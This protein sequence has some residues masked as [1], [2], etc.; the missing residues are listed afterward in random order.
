MTSE[1]LRAVYRPGLKEYRVGIVGAGVTGL[2][3]ARSLLQFGIDNVKIFERMPNLSDTGLR[4]HGMIVAPPG[5]SFLK[6]AEPFVI[7]VCYEI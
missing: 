1:L 7:R 4:N 5:Y 2:T 6:A 3:L